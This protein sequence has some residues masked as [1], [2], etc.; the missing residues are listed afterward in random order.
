MRILAA[1][2]ALPVLVVGWQ[3]WSDH[4]F[5]Q[6][7][8]P[9]ASGVAGRPVRV[10][11]QSFWGGLLDAQ[12]REGEVW[13]DASG[14][15]EGKLFLTRSTC[16]RLRSFAKDRSHSELDC[17]RSVDW[18]APDPLPF[19]SDCYA[20]SADTIYAI[21]ILAHESYHTAGVADE[22]A[23]NCYAIQAMGW[24]AA[25]L[26]AP[27]EEAESIARAMESLEPRQS[28]GYATND[29]RAGLRL[30]LHPETPDFP[31]EHPLAPPRGLG[32]TVVASTG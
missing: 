4:S 6:R 8:Q 23:A 15:P 10:D 17:L 24:T 22:A 16:Q 12:G 11:C 32:G 18:A 7:L 25:Q 28:T 19:A 27:V 14:R 13:F 2:L 9:V 26:G 21:L 5:E 30:D 29:C 31:T 3:L 20:R 1:F